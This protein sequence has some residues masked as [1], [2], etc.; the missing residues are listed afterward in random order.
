ME[1]HFPFHNLSELENMM[2]NIVA[3]GKDN[4]WKLIEE[5]SNAFKRIEKRK[6][7]TLALNK[8]NKGK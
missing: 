2:S 3:E 5:E 6:L 4:M 7:F 8:L 1:N